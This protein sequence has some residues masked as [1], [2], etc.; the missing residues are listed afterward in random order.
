MTRILL[1]QGADT[2][3]LGKR[4]PRFSGTAAA[5]AL[6]AML[7]KE[8]RERRVTLRIEYPHR[9]GQAMDLVCRAAA[10]CVDGLLMNPGGFTHTGFALRECLLGVRLPYVEVHMTN[11]ELRGIKSATA[12]AAVGVIAGLGV[13]SYTL[14]LQA[15][16]GVLEARRVGGGG[17]TPASTGCMGS[18][19]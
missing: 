6:D 19:L 16:L 11:L 7:Q 2:N 13:R 8:A 10:D 18:F 12:A 9:E 15:L 3:H 4:R 5:D 14:G 17:S 1:I